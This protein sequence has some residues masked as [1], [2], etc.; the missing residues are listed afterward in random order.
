MPSRLI[1]HRLRVRLYDERLDLFIGGTH[2]MTPRLV[3]GFAVSHLGL[4]RI[5]RQNWRQPLRPL[6]ADQR[7]PR[8]R[9]RPAAPRIQG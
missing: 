2:L 5:H 6:P 1:G 3:H 9:S 4:F 7:R 8:P